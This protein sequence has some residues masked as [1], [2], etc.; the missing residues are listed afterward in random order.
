MHPFQFP[1]DQG[2]DC[3]IFVGIDERILQFQYRTRTS[4][5]CERHNCTFPGF[6]QFSL[7][8]E[9]FYQDFNGTAASQILQPF[10]RTEPDLRILVPAAVNQRL[11]STGISAAAQLNNS[12]YP[13]F[14]IPVSP[15]FFDDAKN[16][17]RFRQGTEPVIHNTF[18][19]DTHNS[20]ARNSQDAMPI[21]LIAN[22]K[23]PDFHLM[24]KSCRLAFALCTRR[25]MMSPGFTGWYISVLY[26]FQL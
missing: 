18:R 12:R 22:R 7:I 1:S 11:Y 4:D 5:S 16:P 21:L 9:A 2:P 15:C 14:L 8:P 20:S 17:V 6:I 24:K 19:N 25:G 26:S 23:L 10:D 13:L 3:S